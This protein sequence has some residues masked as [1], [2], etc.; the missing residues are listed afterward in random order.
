MGAEFGWE[1]GEEPDVRTSQ[2]PV[3]KH[4][5]Y[6]FYSSTMVGTALMKP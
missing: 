5:N 6:Q 4:I 1:Y 2:V 3:L